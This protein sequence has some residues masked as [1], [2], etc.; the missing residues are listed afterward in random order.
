LGGS[1]A[2]RG[3]A[4]SGSERTA[5][6]AALAGH[7]RP[8]RTLPRRRSG[9][10]SGPGRR[11][12][13]PGLSR[14][15]TAF[16]G[17]ET[18][19]RRP[20]EAGL[21]HPLRLLRPQAFDVRSAPSAVGLGIGRA[22]SGTGGDLFGFGFV[23]PAPNSETNPEEAG[24]AGGRRLMPADTQGTIRLPGGQPDRIGRS[25]VGSASCRFSWRASRASARAVRRRYAPCRRRRR[26]RSKRRAARPPHGS[27]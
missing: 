22:G 10:Q 13:A 11:R 24:R 21:E 15:A 27:P 3:D 17:G 19:A 16:R 25:G 9:G 20:L 12:E 18:R 4:T 8:L 1:G 26:A 2:C 14:S 6:C 5:T 7:A 23:R